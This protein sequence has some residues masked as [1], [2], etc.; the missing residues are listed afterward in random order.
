MQNWWIYPYRY[1]LLTNREVDM[2]GHALHREGVEVNKNTMKL[3]RDHYPVIL[4]QR[5]WSIK[6]L[7][8]AKTTIWS[9]ENNIMRRGNSPKIWSNMFACLF[10]Y[11]APLFFSLVY[12]FPTRQFSFIYAWVTCF[13]SYC[14]LLFCFGNFYDK[15]RKEGR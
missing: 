10:L 7:F 6:D 1:S 8:M 2:A 15:R 13:L 14:M 9:K 11:F 3:E 5:I 12:S 4:N